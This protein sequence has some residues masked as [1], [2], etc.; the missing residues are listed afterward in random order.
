[1]LT[2]Q[3]MNDDATVA[4]AALTVTLIASV[5][6]FF[7]L[8]RLEAALGL[9]FLVLLPLIIIW[10]RTRRL[11]VADPLTIIGANWFLAAALPAF[12]P[13]FYIDP[14]WSRL[15]PELVESATLWMYRGWA[16][17]TVAYWLMRMVPIH[18]SRRPSDRAGEAPL[19]WCVGLVGLCGSIGITILTAGQGY[20]FVDTQ[21][22]ASSFGMVF[23]ELKQ[24]A[25]IYIFLYFQARGRGQ[26]TPQEHKLL[27]AILAAQSAIVAA[28]GSKGAILEMLAAWLIGNAASL[29]RPGMFKE[30]TIAVSALA[31]VYF[32]FNV[33]SQFREEMLR[34]QVSADMSYSDAL[35]LQ[36]DVLSKV[37]VDV[38]SGK[39]TGIPGQ[40]YAANSMLDR[41]AY[42]SALATIFDQT[43]GH[44]PY[45]NA[46]P[47][48]A[49][50]VLA[51]IPRDFVEDKVH[52]FNSGD[53]ARMLGWNYGG[54]SVTV[55]GSMFWAWGYE[56]ILAGM[57]T[58]GALLGMLARRSVIEGVSGL[59]VRAMMFR[60]IMMM[61]DVGQEFQ[62]M[63]VGLVRTGIFLGA[64]TIMTK[65][66]SHRQPAGS[67]FQRRG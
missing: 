54:F 63:L 3:A 15:T 7:E 66:F 49:A 45:E 13:T 5:P 26:L 59:V 47:S 35:S 62:P 52:F 14:L 42:V 28:A 37:S 31:A 17:C 11:L 6:A 20:S 8:S 58:F 25:V 33:I 40:A 23:H 61:L 4:R 43:S 57:A 50:P 53:F 9:T 34:R 55:P 24:F 41:M 56:G 16:A 48:I 10:H 27:I 67:G 38:L 32:T 29:S 21:T 18:A 1:M 12:I 39:Q 2:A 36:L 64:M 65:Y 22:E 30:L 51:L 46:L 44:S 19:R 60:L